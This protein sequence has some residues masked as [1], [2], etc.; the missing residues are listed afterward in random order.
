M[1]LHGQSGQYFSVDLHNAMVGHAMPAIQGLVCCWT[2]ACCY[3]CMCDLIG[4][5]PTA[6]GQ[7]LFVTWLVLVAM[8][9]CAI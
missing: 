9:A 5:G 7:D 1:L 3:D 2:S 6:T 4:P 8:I